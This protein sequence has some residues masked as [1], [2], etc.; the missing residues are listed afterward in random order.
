[1]NYT[2]LQMG[3]NLPAV[4]VLQKLLN[5]SGARL[6]PDGAFG[7]RTRDAVMQFQRQR[8]LSADGVVG[9]DTWP[10]ISSGATLP[11]VDCIDVW[12][13]SLFQLEAGDIQG[14][15]GTPILIG[16]MCNGVE[17]AVQ[18]IVGMARNAFLLRFH[19]HGA[20]GIASVATGQGE[21]DPNT[22]E[23][24]D[25]ALK[26]LEQIRPFIRSMRGIFGPYGCVQF[27]HC[28]T[29]R[30]HSGRQ[31]LHEIA[32][33]LGVPVTAAIREQLGGGLSTFRFEG[34]TVTAFPGAGSLRTWSNALPDFTAYSPS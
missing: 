28:E 15:G 34:P 30:G 17:Q 31:L 9:A 3:D 13:P 32:L 33:D 12:D 21:V 29:G 14:A 22:N 23:R 25:I 8:Q 11:I 6:S 4:G 10:R 16:G 24:S 1:M 27:M 7:P 5:R 18:Q 26:N 2:Y 19:G 20:P